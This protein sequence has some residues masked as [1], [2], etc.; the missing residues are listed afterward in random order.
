MKRSADLRG[1]NE[2]K[3]W[4]CDLYTASGLG[5]LQVTIPSHGLLTAPTPVT[6]ARNNMM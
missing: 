5:A 3:M 6:Q 4:G 2:I 1:L